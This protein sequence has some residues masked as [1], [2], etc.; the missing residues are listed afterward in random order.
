MEPDKLSKEVRALK[1][2]TTSKEE[3]IR[4]LLKE[5]S[6]LK[7]SVGLQRAHIDLLTE[8]LPICCMTRNINMASNERLCIV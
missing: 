4:S 8:V 1:E 6:D 5:I 3:E 7:K 2:G